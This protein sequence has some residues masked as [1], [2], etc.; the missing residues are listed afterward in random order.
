MADSRRKADDSNKTAAAAQS[1]S[2]S[3]SS[4]AHRYSLASKAITTSAPRVPSGFKYSK[5]PVPQTAT[6]AAAPSAST[7][8][9]IAPVQGGSRTATAGNAAEA[10]PTLRGSDALNPRR[11]S[12]AVKPPAT[13]AADAHSGHQTVVLSP[14]PE[15]SEIPTGSSASGRSTRE[16]FLTSAPRSETHG[17]GGWERSTAEGANGSRMGQVTAR[18]L[19][20]DSPTQSPRVNSHVTSSVNALLTDTLRARASLRERREQSDD[21]LLQAI[22]GIAPSPT[23]ASVDNLSH[24]HDNDEQLSQPDV[25]SQRFSNLHGHPFTRKQPFRVRG[26]ATSRMTTS[27]ATAQSRSPE[28]LQT[29][30]AS[31]AGTGFSAHQSTHVDR[32]TQPAGIIKS[33]PR[34]DQLPAASPSSNSADLPRDV[35]FTPTTLSSVV[36]SVNPDGASSMLSE[37]ATLVC[38]PDDMGI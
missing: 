18:R 5:P 3:S 4:M 35:S 21:N 14:I 28:Q 23:I 32:E 13:E 37:L 16:A 22:H 25:K 31:P 11:F 1:S 9:S 38:L 33:T 26:P 10:T 7:P 34:K 17:E 8:P 6:A 12:M 29:S 2:L 30:T 36:K 27:A 19:S 15:E 24:R 20:G